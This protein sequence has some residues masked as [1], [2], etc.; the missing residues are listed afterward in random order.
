MQPFFVNLP[1]RYIAKDRSY[2]DRF[3]E[4]RLAPELG[5]DTIIMSQVEE[6]WH[7]EIAAQLKSARLP[8]SIHL[9]FFDLQPG[10]IDE[11]IL[12]ATRRRLESI[13]KIARI[14]EPVHLVGHAGFT[15]LYVELYEEW[16]SR[17]RATWAGF[18]DTWP[19]HPPLFLENV[20][21]KS[22]APL[23]ALLAGLSGHA[24]GMCFDTGHWHSFSGGHAS[25]TLLQWV[26][27]LR[28][29]IRHLHLHDN[30]GSRDQH[31][32]LGLGSFPWEEL[33]T[34]LSQCALHPSITLE[35]H[36]PED[37]D[38]SVRFMENHPEW[39]F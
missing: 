6:S 11:F 13:K 2:L 12:D 19:G 36:T 10:S 33:F 15:F 38:Q 26:Q 14:Y 30:E 8:C 37:L 18:M 9:P 31:L 23:V 25:G 39:F 21:E 20:F 34:A 1:L 5:I 7:R 22:P 24:A 17:A 29:S 3:I 32:G 16:L 27:P 35:P 28:G 4:R